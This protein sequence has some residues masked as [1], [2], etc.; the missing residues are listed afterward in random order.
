MA[1]DGD[2]PG[3][4]GPP[5]LSGDGPFETGQHLGRAVGGALDDLGRAEAEVLGPEGERRPGDELRHSP[6]G[7]AHSARRR[8]GDAVAPGGGVG[9][10]RPAD[11]ECGPLIRRS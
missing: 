8:I 7:N 6:G 11:R 1:E 10:R 3:R 9:V 5:G 2:R 4:I